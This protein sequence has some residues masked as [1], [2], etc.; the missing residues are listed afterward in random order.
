MNITEGTITG[1]TVFDSLFSLV[2]YD[3]TDTEFKI[4]N[5]TD[6]Y[7]EAKQFEYDESDRSFDASGDYFAISDTKTFTGVGFILFGFPIDDLP[8]NLEF[9]G[10]YEISNYVGSGFFPVPP[11]ILRMDLAGMIRVLLDQL[12][13][14]LPAGLVVLSVFLLVSLLIYTV[15][16]FL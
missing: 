13:M 14:L 5:N 15:R 6:S 9:N 16:S 3:G 11:W 4:T 1:I 10:V 2:M 7:V 12:S 8:Y